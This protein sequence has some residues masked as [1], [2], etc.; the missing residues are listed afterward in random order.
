ML[1]PRVLSSSTPIIP[2]QG[3][4]AGGLLDRL[5]RNL[6]Q[7]G[8]EYCQWKG[9]WSAHRWS[10]GEGDIDLLVDHAAGPSFRRV[11]EELGFK[12]CQ[13][14]GSRQI[15][16][17]EHYVGHDPAVSRL[18]H[19]HIHYRLLLG[20]YWKPVYRL[21]IERALLESAVP[22][23]PF[24]VPAPTHQYLVFV[25]RMMLRQVG[26]PLL[27]AQTLWTTGIR[28]QLDSMEACSD[29]HQLT[30]LLQKHLSPI[31]L[32]F[33]ER[34]ARSLQG[35]CSRLERAA[36]PWE[37]H[38]RLRAHVRR[39]AAGAMLTAAFEKV[40]PAALAE[41]IS[42]RHL[43][44]TA[45]GAVVALVG[46]D[47]AGKSTCARE[48]GAWL[49]PAFP[50]LRAHLGKPPRSLLTL[51]VGGALKLRQRVL[52]MLGRQDRE[53]NWIELLRHLCTARDRY[54]LYVRV[55]RFAVAGGVA[56]CERYPV[57]ENRKLVGPSI[58]DLLPLEPGVIAK[59]LCRWEASYYERI[60]RP[61]ALLVLR[62]HPELAVERKPE[63]PAD[64]V[65]ARG[66]I[67]WDTD[68]STAGAQV[69][70][71][72]QPLPD[73]IRRLKTIIWSHL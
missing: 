28:I 71:A 17:T 62:L 73:V 67:V 27:S 13:P 58:P 61:D 48:L 54:R 11:A 22:G 56:I 53:T 9:H 51:A 30:L 8:V 70:D 60:L 34:C 6:E 46:G 21:P 18:L 31:D 49:E 72:S 24:R 43:R 26:R 15:P 2:A 4:P 35:R 55:R 64:Y 69:V 44:L 68:W 29:R 40:L 10:I 52:G 16:G 33:F 66:Q 19:L 41:R 59:L 47:G 39:P 50:A 5:A 12:P 3:N 25:L 63:E 20:D 65:R 32:T 38:R 45:G 42:A 7:Q 37:L 1:S 57:T 36:L 14:T 23:K